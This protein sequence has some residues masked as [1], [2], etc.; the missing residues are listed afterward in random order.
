MFLLWCVIALIFILFEM[1]SPG[2]FLFLSFAIGAMVAAITT[3]FECTP[4]VSCISFLVGTV[5]S[6]CLLKK[7]LAREN[8]GHAHKTNI[9]ALQGK[10]GIVTQEIKPYGVGAI[11][12]NGEIWSARSIDHTM[13]N[14]GE[15][16]EIVK[17]QGSHAL[18]RD[19][20]L[21]V[22]S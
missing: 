11:N 22:E 13:I 19:A 17:I 1:S 2:L 18:V 14:V 16:V 15:L 3:L 9:Y 10:K 4:L 7:W 21:S 12:V 20:R 8:R 5:L 6:F